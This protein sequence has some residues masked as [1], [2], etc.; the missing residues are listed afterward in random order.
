MIILVLAITYLISSFHLSVFIF[1]FFFYKIEVCFQLGTCDCFLCI[2][3]SHS[4]ALKFSPACHYVN[5]T[6]TSV[7]CL[8]T[9]LS[10]MK[11]LAPV[12]IYQPTRTISNPIH[13][14]DV[15]LLSTSV[16]CEQYMQKTRR[17]LLFCTSDHAIMFNR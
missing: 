7:D 16:V 9:E 8:C 4:D 11:L 6:N 5:L 10:S 12:A 13:S 17:C 15:T 3:C 14:V 1:F 2:S